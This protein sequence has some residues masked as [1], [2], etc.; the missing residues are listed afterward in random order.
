MGAATARVH[1]AL[2]GTRDETVVHEEIFI[3]SNAGN[4]A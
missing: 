4:D 1:Q 2:H 3:S